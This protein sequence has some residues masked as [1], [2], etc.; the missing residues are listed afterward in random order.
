[1][2]TVAG[3]CV[4]TSVYEQQRWWLCTSTF[5]NGVQF[6]LGFRSFFSAKPN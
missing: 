3:D 2:G 5:Q 6:P 1:V 4:L